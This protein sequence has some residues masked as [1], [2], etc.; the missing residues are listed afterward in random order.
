MAE[1]HYG[2]LLSWASVSFHLGMIGGHTDTR[3]FH[4]CRWQYYEHVI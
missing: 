3:L 1:L 4:V 2:W